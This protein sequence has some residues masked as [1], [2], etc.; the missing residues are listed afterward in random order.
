LRGKRVGL[1]DP[2][3]V[4]WSPFQLTIKTICAKKNE[5]YELAQLEG[6]ISSE[7]ELQSIRE[8]MALPGKRKCKP[9]G[10][11]RGR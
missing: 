9:R 5:N 8:E 4:M 2:P 11:K 10:G 6:P 1:P 7:E 3:K